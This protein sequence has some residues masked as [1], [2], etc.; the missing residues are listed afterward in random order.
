MQPLWGQR[1]GAVWMGLRPTRNYEKPFDP[2]AI[3]SWGSPS[4]L[5]PGFR[6]AR[7]F[8][9]TSG[10]FFNGAAELLPGAEL[11]VL[12]V[13]PAI[14]SPV[15]VRT[16]SSTDPCHCYIVTIPKVRNV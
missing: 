14:L 7:S 4:G 13:A 5:P 3:S 10:R 12:P 2:P 16:A 9:V 1:F 6:P 15:F 8:A 11:Y